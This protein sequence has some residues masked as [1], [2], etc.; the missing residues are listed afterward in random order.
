MYVCHLRIV[1][2]ARLARIVLNV[3]TMF[4]AALLARSL[5]KKKFLISMSFFF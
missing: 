1:C 4:Y 3:V 5:L 2:C